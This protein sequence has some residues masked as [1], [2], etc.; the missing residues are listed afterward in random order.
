[1]SGLSHT[2]CEF[3]ILTSVKGRRRPTEPG[4]GA[5]PTGRPVIKPAANQAVFSKVFST[6]RKLKNL[7]GLGKAVY[8]TESERERHD[9]LERPLAGD[10]E[11]RGCDE[12]RL[13]ERE[14]AALR[15]V[16]LDECVH[17]GRNQEEVI[18][19]ELL[20]SVEELGEGREAGREEDGGDAEERVGVDESQE[21]VHVRERYYA[22]CGVARGGDGA[23]GGG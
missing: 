4:A 23:W 21:A 20:D 11:R 1:M 6:G 10:V 2:T 15:G 12:T 14:R 13:C 22:Q 19:L 16:V 17:E 18:D 8:L 9:R 3:T 7:T 5:T